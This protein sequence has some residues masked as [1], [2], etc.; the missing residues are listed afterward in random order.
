MSVTTY[1][2]KVE[3]ERNTPKVRSRKRKPRPG[4]KMM[5]CR[6]QT[7]KSQLC[8]MN[9]LKVASCNLNDHEACLPYCIG[10]IKT[11]QAPKN[12]RLPMDHLSQAIRISSLFL[13][14]M[15]EGCYY[16]GVGDKLTSAYSGGMKRRLSVACSFIGDPDIVFLDEPSTVCIVR[17]RLSILYYIGIL[18]KYFKIILRIIFKK[19]T[20]L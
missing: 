17:P 20:T 15:H 10:P 4:D 1:Q 9:K 16:G 11:P 13:Q 2:R 12:K 7:I 19:F 3:G 14:L 5:D 8:N 18:I 6:K